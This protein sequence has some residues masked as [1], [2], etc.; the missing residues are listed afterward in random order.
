MNQNDDTEEFLSS[1]PYRIEQNEKQKLLLPLLNKLT[2]VHVVACPEYKKILCATCGAP[3]YKFDALEELP[4]LPVRLFKEYNLASVEKDK[5]IK[6]LTSSGTTSQRVSKINLDRDTARY[7]TKALVSI[8]KNYI[9]D[10]RL[11]MLIIDHPNVI[12]DRASFS[13]RGAGILGLMNFG[14]DVTYLL[15]ES[16][17]IDFNV[18]GEFLKKYSDEPIFIFGF[19]FMV[20]QYLYKPLKENNMT[21]DISQGILVHSGGWKKLQDQAVDNKTFKDKIKEA[22]GVASIHNFYG[23]VEQVGSIYVECEEGHL[24]APV[25]SD[26]II[27]NP[28][29]WSVASDGEYGVIQVLS[30]L[31]HSYPGHSLLTEDLGAIIGV[32]NCPCGRKGKYFLVSGRVP[33]AEIRGCS[34]TH[35]NEM[36][37]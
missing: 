4:F 1:F 8:M 6:V 11:P 15:N 14:R 2:R 28:Y 29:D 34:D 27:R 33:R 37:L 30:V 35:A 21:I 3:P 13:A 25:F 19:T 32:D 5:I 18:L 24:H 23:M 22:T 16:M 7:Q 10:K 9:G 36:T 20:W 12:R 31:P 17:E 26:V